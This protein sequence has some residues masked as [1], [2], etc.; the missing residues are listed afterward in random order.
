MKFSSEQ[1]SLFYNEL[2]KLAGSGFSILES[3]DAVLDNHPPSAQ[4]SY[5]QQ[6]KQGVGNEKLTIAESIDRIEG[7]P[8][9]ELEKTVIDAAEKGGQLERGFAHLAEYFAMT[10]KAARRVRSQLVYPAILLHAA[11]LLPMAPRLVMADDKGKVIAQ[12][13]AI[14]F[15][16]YV[17]LWIGWMVFGM[18][19]RKAGHCAKADGILRRL[20]L[21]GKVRR[22]LSMSRFSKVMEI[23]LLAGQRIDTS[24]KAAGTASQS[25]IVNQSLTTRVVPEVE[26]GNPAG[27]AFD[28]SVFPPTFVRSYTTAEQS[29]TLDKD[30]ARWSKAF[31]EEAVISL[32]R[33]SKWAP[34]VVYVVVAAFVIVQIFSLFKNVYLEPLKQFGL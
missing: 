4:R 26:S 5:L 30:M 33:L 18:L 9:S 7:V 3:A 2:A 20:P 24:L 25:G 6:L 27:P 11:I 13:A 8:I 16:L 12:T 29:G 23:F 31:H 15:G 21:V 28:K 19:H 32:E 34:K 1:K 10:D 22:S 14:L 17:V